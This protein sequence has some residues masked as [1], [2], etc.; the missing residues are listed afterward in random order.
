MNWNWILLVIERL[1]SLLLSPIPMIPL[2]LWFQ[3]CIHNYLI[4]YVIKPM[5]YMVEDYLFM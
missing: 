3:L 4:S 5:M 1:P 2:T